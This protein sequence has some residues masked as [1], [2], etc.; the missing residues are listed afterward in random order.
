MDSLNKNV[1]IVVSRYN[2][3]LSWINE[4]PFN[5]FEYIIYN[6]GDNDN[7]VKT[8]VKSIVKLP[9]V[10]M[11]DHTYLY[12][13]INNYDLLSNITVFF[14][15]SVY[16]SGK[17]NT[18]IMILNNIINSNY[19]NAYF[20]GTYYKS[21]KY[22]FKNFILNNHTCACNENNIKNGETK[23]LKCKIRPYGK[24]Y[25]FFFGNTPAHWVTCGG[26]FSIDKKDIIQYPIHRYIKLIQTVNAY[27]NHEAAHY[28]ERS[29]G[30]I[31]FPMIYTVKIKC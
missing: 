9:N 21:I 22:S 3:D 14:P 26:V 20:I 30:V 11:C 25:D 7:F 18:A 28:I 10:G 1:E 16:L 17:K 31:F 8:N 27:S 6:K 19:N 15:G 24:W 5:Q 23:L 12:H 13:I 4:Y 29:W 2:E